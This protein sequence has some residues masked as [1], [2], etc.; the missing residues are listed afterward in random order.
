MIR[1]W[2]PRRRPR[3]R[4]R[5][6]FAPGLA[7]DGERPLRG[8]ARMTRETVRWL[9]PFGAACIRGDVRRGG[10]WGARLRGPCECGL[11]RAPAPPPARRDAA[12]SE[13]RLCRGGRLRGAL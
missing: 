11:G 7:V 3:L 4:K 6:E 9:G 13:P 12:G 1:R 5:T 8:S 10:R 2:E